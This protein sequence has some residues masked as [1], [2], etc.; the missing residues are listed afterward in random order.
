MSTFANPLTYLIL[1]ALH[2]LAWL[3]AYRCIRPTR[4]R[5]RNHGQTAIFVVI[6]DAAVALAIV[7]IVAAS[8][9]VDWLDLA[10][11]LSAALAAGGL[12]MIWEYIDDHTSTAQAEYQRSYTADIQRLLAQED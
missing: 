3:Y 8:G 4:Q 7:L 6:G 9:P 10:A 5:Q 1:I 12:P 2:S 11:I